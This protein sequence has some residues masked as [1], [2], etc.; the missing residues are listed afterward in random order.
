[1]QIIG[2][3]NANFG[4]MAIRATYL[5]FS[6]DPHPAFMTLPASE[7]KEIQEITYFDKLMK[8]SIHYILYYILL[9]G[10]FF[11]FKI[12]FVLFSLKY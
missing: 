9:I 4:L 3:R 6:F 1:M 5:A 11:N 12:K 8:L 2:A 7:Y 10:K